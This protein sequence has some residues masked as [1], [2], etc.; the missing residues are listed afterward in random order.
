M[1]A[2]DIRMLPKALALINKDGVDA[3]FTVTDRQYD[4]QTSR[5]V[6]NA[7][8]VEVT[9]KISP[10]QG[11]NPRQVDNT[12]VLSSD[13]TALVAAFGLTFTPAVHMKVTVDAVDY[14]VEKIT[15]YRSG[16]SVCVYE[17]VLRT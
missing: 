12:T 13:L 3:V 9:R 14:T 2:L 17:L 15:P 1:T 10:P 6:D 4:A 8:P 11:V 7:G 16:E 5:I